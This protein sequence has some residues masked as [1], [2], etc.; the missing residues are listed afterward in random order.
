MMIAI[1][2]KTMAHPYGSEMPHSGQ[3]E[4]N[5]EKPYGVERVSRDLRDFLWDWQVP[6]LLL[7]TSKPHSARFSPD[8][9]WILSHHISVVYDCYCQPF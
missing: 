2:M 3:W 7:P 9:L 8:E 1:S 6:F 5:V 4:K